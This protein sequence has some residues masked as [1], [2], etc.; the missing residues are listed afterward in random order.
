MALLVS[1]RRYIVRLFA[2]CRCKVLLHCYITIVTPMDHHCITIVLP[3][4]HYCVT[5]V[6]LL[7]NCD[8]ILVILL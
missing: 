2:A 5:T 7:Y 3:Q 1:F 6:T 8:K 4:D